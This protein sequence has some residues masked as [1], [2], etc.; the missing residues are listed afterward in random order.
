MRTAPMKKENERVFQARER[1]REIDLIPVGLI[2]GFLSVQLLLRR[3]NQ[4]R[5][6]IHRQDF[7]VKILINGLHRFPSEIF[8]F[9]TR[10]HRLK[11][12]L[13]PPTKMVEI[14]EKGKRIEL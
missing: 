2:A 3:T 9:E 6:Q 5:R 12:F 7:G 13:D 14:E 10:F 4:N 11:I 8:Y 1:E